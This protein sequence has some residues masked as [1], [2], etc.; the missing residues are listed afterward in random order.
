M[1]TSQKDV[2]ACFRRW[3][4]ALRP[5]FCCPVSPVAGARS[6]AMSDRAYHSHNEHGTCEQ[7]QRCLWKSRAACKKPRCTCE[8]SETAVRSQKPYSKGAAEPVAR[9]R[10]GP[11]CSGLPG[12]DSA[13]TKRSCSLPPVCPAPW[14][15]PILARTVL[16][17]R[18]R[19]IAGPRSARHPPHCG[20]GQERS[21]EGSLLQSAG[22]SDVCHHHGRCAWPRGG[23]ACRV[24]PP[25][26]KAA[27]LDESWLTPDR[28][29]RS[30]RRRTQLSVWAAADAFWRA[31]RSS[32]I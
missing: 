7:C 26:R 31:R 24:Q 1:D 17:D 12:R 6:A 21:G 9:C 5:G 22:R 28:R 3:Y 29:V 23:R 15:S 4:A 32:S 13:S 18:I 16:Y 25:V 27:S 20:V 2:S 11:A 30:L 8:G 14:R 10:L 19:G